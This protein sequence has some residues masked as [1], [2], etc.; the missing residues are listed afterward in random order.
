MTRLGIAV[1]A[2]M[3]EGTIN[4]LVA[5]FREGLTLGFSREHLL[6]DMTRLLVSEMDLVKAAS[7]AS[8]AISMLTEERAD[9]HV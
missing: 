4:E 2:I 8:M 9:A 7:L 6:Q 1:E 3:Y 5:I